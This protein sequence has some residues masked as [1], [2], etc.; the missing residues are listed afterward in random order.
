MYVTISESIHSCSNEISFFVHENL[1]ITTYL[2]VI[3]RF[4]WTKNEISLNNY[5]LIQISYYNN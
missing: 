3:I 5:E 1:I 2:V 4:L